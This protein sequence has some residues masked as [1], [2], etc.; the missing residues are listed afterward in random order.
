MIATEIGTLPG[1]GGRL[2]TLQLLGTHD[3]NVWLYNP[4]DHEVIARGTWQAVLPLFAGSILSIGGSKFMYSRYYHISS[5]VGS[6]L[7]DIQDLPG[8][9]I[10]NR[11]I[12]ECV[13]VIG[14]SLVVGRVRS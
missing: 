13:K 9:T 6:D 4:F 11:H 8:K 2:V 5:H 12:I 14:A 3:A 10:H 1:L 7:I